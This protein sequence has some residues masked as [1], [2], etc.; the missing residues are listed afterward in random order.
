MSRADQ[1]KR[2]PI[3]EQTA[4][5]EKRIGLV[6]AA[7]RRAGSAGI[8]FAELAAEVAVRIPKSNDVSRLLA[9]AKARGLV[10]SDDRRWVAIEAKPEV[11]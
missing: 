6:V 1:T 2:G 9:E 7:V 5:R 10:R 8:A 11:V 4:E 3:A